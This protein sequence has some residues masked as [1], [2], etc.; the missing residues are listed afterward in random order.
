MY[1]ATGLYD[2]LLMLLARSEERRL[3][4]TNPVK[5]RRGRIWMEPFWNASGVL[6]AGA[7]RILPAEA[8]AKLHD[9]L[10]LAL[11]GD[12]KTYPLES[13]CVSFRRAADLCAQARES[14]GSDAAIYC[15]TT[16]PP[17]YGEL[18]YLTVEIMRHALAGLRRVR[19][20]PCRPRLVIAMD[21]YALDML[22][23][24]KEGAYA[25]F[26][27]RYHLGFDRLVHLRPLLGRKVLG[28][29]IGWPSTARRIFGTLGS[30]GEVAMVLGGG[31]PVTGRMFYCTREFVV[32]LYRERPEAAGPAVPPAKLGDGV[33]ADAALSAPPAEI[34]ER[35]LREAPGFAKFVDSGILGGALKKNIRRAMEA[36]V[37]SS[38]AGEAEF[39]EVEAGRPTAACREALAA[40]AKALGWKE[41]A[42]RTVLADFE[43]EFKRETPYRERLFSLLARRVA[44]RGRPVVLLPLTHGKPGAVAMRYGEPV[45]LLDARENEVRVLRPGG[46]PEWTPLRRFCR[47]FVGRRYS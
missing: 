11:T 31:L 27:G 23:M 18:L 13:D 19:G 46:E 45:C 39:K 3:D 21:Y 36:W 30:G 42:A 20:K 1:P 35:L 38:L 29:R 47:D 25:G 43:E 12:S 17:A 28:S 9:M 8:T 14:T 6:L 15:L 5:G 24:Y 40:V 4:G 32:R 2:D 26:V 34:R 41:A 10:F 7:F 16:H 37:L 22:K 44:G 33:L